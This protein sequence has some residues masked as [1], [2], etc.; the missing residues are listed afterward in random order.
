MRLAIIG[1]GALGGVIGWYRSSVAGHEVWLQDGWAEY[2][3]TVALENDNR[4]RFADTA[5]R[6]M[7]VNRQKRFAPPL[8]VTSVVNPLAPPPGACAARIRAR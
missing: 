1:A 8:W 7:A 4:L 2:M 3:E 6:D 5:M